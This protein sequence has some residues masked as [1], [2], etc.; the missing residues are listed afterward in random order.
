[1][2]TLSLRTIGVAYKKLSPNDDINSNNENGVFDI[3]SFG[4]TYL[5]IVGIRDILR[6][7]VK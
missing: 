4:L 3:E 2:A 7:G 6:D 1:M 5:S